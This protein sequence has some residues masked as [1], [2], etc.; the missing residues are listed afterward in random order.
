MAGL[1][2]YIFLFEALAVWRS[3]TDPGP[4]AIARATALSLAGPALV[5]SFLARFGVS[6]GSTAGASALFACV[7]GALTLRGRA[8]RPALSL[9]VVALGLA[10]AVVCPLPGI[11]P[12]SAAID[13]FA[14]LAWSKD[15]VSASGFYVPGFPAF[16]ST[17]TAQDALVGA[18]RVAPALLLVAL[19]LTVVAFGR[20]QGWAWAGVAG[21][22]ALI[23]FP[24]IGG[25][26]ALARPE[27]M[28]YPLIVASWM[29]LGSLRA[30][31]R[32]AAVWLGLLSLALVV[33]HVSI[34]EIAHLVALGLT[35]LVAGQV[36][37]SARM[38]AVV[39]LVAGPALAFALAPVLVEMVFGEGLLLL[40]GQPSRLGPFSLKGFGAGLG[41]FF[42][43][44]LLGAILGLALAG[45]RAPGLVARAAPFAV[46]TLLLLS[47]MLLKSVG[48]GFPL[49]VFNGRLYV[50]A[51]LFVVL[52]WIALVAG[53]AETRPGVAGWIALLPVAGIVQRFRDAPLF[54]GLLGVAA[55]STW[56]ASRIERR[57][58]VRKLAT[59]ALLVG[60]VVSVRMLVW[61]P[62][63]A[64]WLRA[65]RD[66]DPAGKVVLT[67]WPAYNAVQART[68]LP[69]ELGIGGSDAG[70][71]LHAISVLPP[72]RS[73]LR[74]SADSAAA[75][76]EALRAW[77][78]GRAEDEVLVLV[79]RDLARAWTGY[80]DGYAQRMA[81]GEL[82]SDPVHRA[83]PVTDPATERMRRI[84]AAL[85]SLGPV[86]VGFE[87]SE[88]TLYVVHPGQLRAIGAAPG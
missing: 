10:A 13:G 7:V 62:V 41:P 8:P 50:A 71:P 40:E 63:D 16:V 83:A 69:V 58:P 45:R 30:G 82:D 87:D 76:R 29:E 68:Q 14:H 61:T 75:D 39:A 56:F 3:R 53:I 55:V 74:W 12:D 60:L 46:A 44:S 54:L 48:L 2:L 57:T 20:S 22:A 24:V 59:L 32:D 9:A 23:S 15:L 43:L 36:A 38:R 27:L 66:L 72:L 88:A 51:S 80:A 31:R 84:D 28:A 79:H 65:L 6:G 37:W 47:P 17:L 5:L 42:D 26:L 19:F 25:R 1:V 21:C 33:V 18:F 11:G 77:L 78:I 64:D 86:E 81:A 35:I 85:R 52:G 67:H 4:L 73:S 34:L 70:L 49:Q